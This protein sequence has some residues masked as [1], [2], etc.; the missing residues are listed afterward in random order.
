MSCFLTSL[1]PCYTQLNLEEGVTIG[2]GYH[3][4][5]AVIV[6]M[7]VIGGMGVE[8]WDRGVIGNMGVVSL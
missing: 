1:L 3:W 7:G 8:W 5:I 6:N 4:W 2:M